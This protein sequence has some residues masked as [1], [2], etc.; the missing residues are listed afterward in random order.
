MPGTAHERSF[1]AIK[2]D[3][4]QRG[5]VSEVIARFEK[6][7]YKLVA[8]KMVWPSREMAAKHYDDLK[9]RPFFPALVKYF[10]SGP[11]VAMVWEGPGVI[12][13][14][15]KILGA[16]NPNAA[17]IGTLRGDFCLT[18]GRNIIHGSDGPDSAKHEI[19]MWFSERECSNW[20][21]TL[22][23]WIVADN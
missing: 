20:D 12:L 7:G 1:I 3:G 14:G 22:D 10:S 6:K 17:D 9:E 23:S 5:L 15:R 19:G 21:R 8:M 18:M 4:V 2:P 16:T 13:T 11:I